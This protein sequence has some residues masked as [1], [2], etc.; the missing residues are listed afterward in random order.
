[1]EMTTVESSQVHI[2]GETSQWIV[3]PT[4]RVIHPPDQPCLMCWPP[5]IP[6]QPLASKHAERCPVCEGSGRTVLPVAS[7]MSGIEC[8]A[9]KGRGWIEVSNW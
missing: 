1:M 4:H 9:C 2:Y 5:E 8:H 7:D 3:C 6:T